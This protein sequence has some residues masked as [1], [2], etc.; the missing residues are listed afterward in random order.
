ML[1]GRARAPRPTCGCA[2]IGAGD[3][4]KRVVLFDVESSKIGSEALS[5]AEAPNILLYEA[6]EGSLGL[7][8]QFVGDPSVINRVI[9]AAIDILRYGEAY[10]VA[11]ERM[12]KGGP[13]S[14]ER[15]SEAD[16]CFR[17]LT[18]RMP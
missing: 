15:E 6:T 12:A 2:E 4:W 5:E 8:S 13:G 11:G 14:E 7:L 9:Q 3:H 16:F 10:P 17:G 1:G 18:L